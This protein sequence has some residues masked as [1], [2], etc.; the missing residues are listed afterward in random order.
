MFDF[1]QLSHLLSSLALW[2]AIV[3]MAVFLVIAATGIFLVWR[4]ARAQERT[5]AALEKLTERLGRPP[6]TPV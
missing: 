3:P 2:F 4:L 6:D 1:S 5:A